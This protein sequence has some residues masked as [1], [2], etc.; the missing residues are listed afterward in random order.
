[1]LFDGEEYVLLDELLGGLLYLGFVLFDGEE[2][3]LL[4][5]PLDGL[6]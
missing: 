3:V 2:Y 4:D 6:L 1:V 5:E